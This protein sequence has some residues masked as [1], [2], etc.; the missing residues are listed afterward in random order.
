MMITH[1]HYTK[2]KKKK[3]LFSFNLS[4]IHW[5]TVDEIAK[6]RQIHS[7]IKY[8]ESINTITFINTIILNNNLSVK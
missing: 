5:I 4:F 8:N 3:N 7:F 2:K 6:K 1:T